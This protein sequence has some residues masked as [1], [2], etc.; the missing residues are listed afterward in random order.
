M[1]WWKN[2]LINLTRIF[3]HEIGSWVCTNIDQRSPSRHPKKR[4]RNCNMLSFYTDTR[5]T[6]CNTVLGLF[7]PRCNMINI[8]PSSYT[9]APAQKR[10]PDLVS[11]QQQHAPCSLACSWDGKHGG[12]LLTQPG[13]WYHR[14]SLRIRTPATFSGDQSHEFEEN[15]SSRGWCC[16]LVLVLY[17][18]VEI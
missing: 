13:L 18:L 15:H 14:T 10:H 7:C 9:G 3:V 1:P 17:R 8:P 5:M 12:W 4:S 6:F 2:V 16:L 11:S